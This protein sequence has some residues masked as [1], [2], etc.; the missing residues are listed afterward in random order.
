MRPIAKNCE[1]CDERFQTK[2]LWSEHTKA[3]KCAKKTD[4][5]AEEDDWNSSDNEV[6]MLDEE[7]DDN[8][9]ST[10][11]MEETNMTETS[12]EAVNVPEED[13]EIEVVKSTIYKYQGSQNNQQDIKEDVFRFKYFDDFEDNED[14][15]LLE[16]ENDE[17]SNE[18]MDSEDEDD[19]PD[20]VESLQKC[21]ECDHYFEERD[22]AG[23][24]TVNHP[25]QKKEM[26]H[27]AGGNFFMLAA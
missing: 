17:E 7:C 20:P 10:Q 5:K 24:V 13:D 15:V 26:K 18:S 4:I 6:I 16:D 1:I 2:K 23:H 22:L 25:V 11:T 19:S 12:S 9:G 27:F 21:G 3:K 14:V 8:T